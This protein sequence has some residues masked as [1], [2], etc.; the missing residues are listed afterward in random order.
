MITRCKRCGAV[1]MLPINEADPDENLHIRDA[2]FGGSR[3]IDWLH[4][5]YRAHKNKTVDEQIDSGTIW[6]LCND[7]D[8]ITNEAQGGSHDNDDQD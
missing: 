1:L 6:A 8:R 2:I 5:D 4:W 7:C 3:E